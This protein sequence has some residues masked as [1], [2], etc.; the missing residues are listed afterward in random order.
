[1]TGTARQRA[2]IIGAGIGGLTAALALAGKGWDV[3]VIERTP[4][5]KPVGYALA[6]APNAQRALDAI[7]GGIVARIHALAALQGDGGIRKR[8]G[9]LAVPQ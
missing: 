8:P 3:Q 2:I 4:K 7:P 6:M 1:M 5:L 9:C